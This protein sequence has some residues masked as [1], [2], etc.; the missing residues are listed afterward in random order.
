MRP[1]FN[2]VNVLCCAVPATKDCYSC[3]F[4]AT[5]ILVSDKIVIQELRSLRKANCNAGVAVV[6]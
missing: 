1:V 2:V 5:A 4:G 6:V 3:G